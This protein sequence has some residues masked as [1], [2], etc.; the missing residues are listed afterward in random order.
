MLWSGIAVTAGVGGRLAG[1]VGGKFYGGAVVGAAMAAVS[2][3]FTYFLLTKV[4]ILTAWK[5]GANWDRS[6]VLH[7]RR[8]G[9]G[10]SILATRTTKSGRKI[11]LF[12]GRSCSKCSGVANCEPEEKRRAGDG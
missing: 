12:S 5:F 7:W 8:G 2:P 4:G 10:R 1:S 11:P 9:M 6:R 3:A